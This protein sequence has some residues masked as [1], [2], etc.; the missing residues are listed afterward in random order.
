MP[1]TDEKVVHKVFGLYFYFL[2][3]FFFFLMWTIFLKSLLNLLHYYFCSMVWPF[4]HEACGILV[5]RPGIKSTSP[6]L[7]GEVS[8]SGLSGKSRVFGF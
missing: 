3:D 7:E 2:K 5:L 8:T 1:I 6:A 4:S